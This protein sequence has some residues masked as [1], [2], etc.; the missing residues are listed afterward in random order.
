MTTRARRDRGPAAASTL[1]PLAVGLAL[2]WAVATA[3]GAEP[4]P[5][6]AECPALDAMSAKLLARWGEVPVM[7][8]ASLT[9]IDVVLYVSHRGTWSWVRV[10]GCAVAL[11]VDGGVLR[12]LEGL[13]APDPAALLGDP[14]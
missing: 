9:G 1:V 8:G 10:I 11:V 7:R 12:L 3:D 13:P 4:D 5:A 2:L 6:P 14:A